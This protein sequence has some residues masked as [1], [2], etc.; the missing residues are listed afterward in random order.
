M[1]LI[2]NAVQT[3]HLQLSEQVGEVK[4]ALSRHV[5]DVSGAHELRV[6]KDDLLSHC[7]AKIMDS[8]DLCIRRFETVIGGDVTMAGKTKCIA[9][10]RETIN[11]VSHIIKTTPQTKALFNTHLAQKPGNNEFIRGDPV[12][13][14]GG[15]KM[16]VGAI[17]P[18]SSKSPTNKKDMSRNTTVLHLSNTSN[19]HL[20]Q[21]M[22]TSSMLKPLTSP[23]SQHKNKYEMQRPFTAEGCRTIPGTRRKSDLLPKTLYVSSVFHDVDL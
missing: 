13:Y 17:P 1:E 7:N 19:L 2:D 12:V 10:S 9:C 15:F 16:S 4:G 14:R 11:G 8:M 20:Q 23:P 21:S 5:E 18:S 6:F 3:L 22:S